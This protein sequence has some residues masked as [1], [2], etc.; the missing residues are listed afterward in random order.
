MS[1]IKH[2]MSGLSIT[3]YALYMHTSAY[4]YDSIINVYPFYTSSDMAWKGWRIEKRQKWKIMTATMC[5]V[6]ACT[7]YSDLYVPLLNPIY[8]SYPLI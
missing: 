3:L 2:L 4:L 7:K 5:L 1:F 6:S 8:S